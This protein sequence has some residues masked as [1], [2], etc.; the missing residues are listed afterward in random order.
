MLFVRRTDTPSD[1]GKAKAPPRTK[2]APRDAAGDY[3]RQRLQDGQDCLDAALD[4]LARGWSALAVCPPDHV[5]V[6][7]TH[8]KRCKSPGKAPWGEWKEFQTR[9]PT[10]AGLRGK[11]RDNSQ[12]NVGMPLGPVSGLIGV[13]VDGL[14]GEAK[15]QELSGGDLPP[16]LEFTS[17]RPEG[18]RRLLYA[19]PDGV[20]LR[21]T[22]QNGEQHGGVSLLAKG[23][24]TVMPPS[25]HASGAR[26]AWKPG[27]G[28][29][30][31][32]PAPAPGWLV[33]LLS[34]EGG[35]SRAAAP[36]K[37]GEPIREGAR[38]TTLTSLAGTMRRTGMG[39]EAIRAA[40][41]AENAERC[42]PPLDEAEVDGIAVSVSRYE[43]DEKARREGGGKKSQATQL[44]ALAQG[45]ELFH[46][47]GGY[48]S[49]GYASLEVNGHRETWPVSS[50]GLR[51][52]LSKRFYEES[53][54]AP[55]S[56]A[57]QDALNVIAGKAVHE[58][59]EYEVAVRLAEQA[60]TIWLDLADPNWRAVR[61]GP[62]GWALVDDCPVRFVRRRGMLALPE[63]VPGGRLEE[64]RPLVNLPDDDAWVLFAAWLVAVPRP[65]RPFPILA[66]NGEQGSAK[67]TLCRMAR[68][69]ID[70]NEAPLRRPPHDVRDLMIAACNGWVVGYDNLSGL[71]PDLSDAL[72]CLATG[73]GFG[74][75]QLYTDDEEKLFSATRPIV[76]NGIEDIATR[77]DLLDRAVTLTLPPIPDEW[78]R[79]EDEL[80]RLYE[81]MRP[82]VLGALLG[83]VSTALK[84]LPGTQLAGKPRMADF[85][86]WATASEPA[87][88]LPEGAFL[89][90]YQGNR[91]E[92]NQAALDSSPVVKYLLQLVGREPWSGTAGKLLDLLQK[93]ATDNEKRLNDWPQTARGLSGILRRLAPNLRQAGVDVQFTDKWTR[94]GKVIVLERKAEQP[95]QPLQPLPRPENS[96]DAGNGREPQPSQ[97]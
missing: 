78:R 67:T 29:G 36:L 21:T 77:P 46:T 34:A 74:T 69:L 19:I 33:K 37:D 90:A 66:V 59:P 60:G 93:R 71:R 89:R 24:Q 32:E 39:Y 18:G 75:R 95:L 45:V 57:L 92:S 30:E 28:P 51:R 70:P 63:P 49:E 47:P 15:L 5:G 38:N 76:L 81:E 14:E 84:R 62:D 68:G 83:A 85:A 79:D 61:I 52:W 42:D 10:E 9:L 26:Y 54:T 23:S 48:D 82:R 44:V 25:R 4:Y 94:K 56:Q 13:D 86:L 11:W 20:E 88:G 16:T 1:D 7:K 12:L 87:L 53:G 2:V 31:I 22:H 50:K 55:G 41:L 40:L 17:G 58:G 91:A 8:G 96:A 97:P 43:P 73:G 72:C 80:W 65:R 3:Q 6:G 27:L 64:L 35:K